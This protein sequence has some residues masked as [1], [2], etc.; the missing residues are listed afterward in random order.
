MKKVLLGKK[1]GKD[2]WEYT[3][4]KGDL[5]AK[6]LNFGGIISQ[7]SFA[8]VSVI[9]TY[10]TLEDY[11]QDTFYYGALVGRVANR[12]AEG[13]FSING[14]PYQASQNAG[15]HT[16]HGGFSSFS[17]KAWE[18]VFYNEDS[19]TLS[20]TSPDGEEGFPGNL[21]VT[22]TYTLTEKQGLLI[23]Y[24]AK[25]D[26]DTVVSLTNHAYFNLSGTPSA[27]E[28]LLQI[29]AD[30]ITLTDKDLIPNGE[31]EEVEGTPFDF[32]LLRLLSLHPRIA[33]KETEKTAYDE[34]YVLAGEGFRFVAALKSPKTGIRMDVYTDARGLQL[35]TG[36]PEEA[37]ALETQALP[38][39]INI[40]TFP[41]PIL[42][43]GDTYRTATEYRFY[44]EK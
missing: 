32:R 22:V 27:E 37:I 28:H 20:Y 26:K 25:T 15:C 23:A 24:S 19:L 14:I 33:G 12:I 1:D 3:L 7:L 2:V 42:R 13:K 8:G 16:L 10:P 35:Y 39:A 18:E 31:M 43:V 21:E 44:L 40:P 38:N 41:S 30:K 4:E 36:N 34:N 29:A 6:I 9:L 17:K 5:S 11:I